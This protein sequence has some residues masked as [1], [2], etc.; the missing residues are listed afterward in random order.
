M[1]LTALYTKN[2]IT[3]IKGGTLHDTGVRPAPAPSEEE[4]I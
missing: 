2:L 3:I 1:L 4:Q